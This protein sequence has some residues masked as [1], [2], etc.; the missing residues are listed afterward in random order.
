[1]YLKNLSLRG[2]KT[3]ADKTV[4]EFNPPGSIT[5]IV[6]PNGCGKS[7]LVDAIRWV[8]GEQNPKELRSSALEEVIFAGSSA[9]KPLSLAEVS[10]D[11][12][13]TDNKIKTEFAELSIKRRTFRSGESEFFINKANCRLKDIR[14]IFLDTGLGAGSYSIISQGRVDAVLSSKPEERREIF[15]EAAKINKYKFRK[16]AAERKLISTEQNMLRI[17][18]LKSEISNQLSV[19]EEQSKKAAQ[20][21]ELKEKL[22]VLEVG[23]S[24]RQLTNITEKKRVIDE[25]ISALKSQMELGLNMTQQ[26]EAEKALKKETLRS[27]Q[28]EIEGLRL[29]VSQAKLL[30]EENKSSILLENEKKRNLEERI[31]EAKA[32]FDE[33]SLKLVSLKNKEKEL[34]QELVSSQDTL[35]HASEELARSE[36]SV[37]RVRIEQEKLEGNASE[38]KSAILEKEGALSHERNRFIELESNLRLAKEELR[39]DEELI[40]KL[41]KEKQELSEKLEQLNVRSSSLDSKLKSSESNI[42]F[43]ASTETLKASFCGAHGLAAK[44]ASDG[45]AYEIGMELI[46]GPDIKI[47]NV[48]LNDELILSDGTI[49]GGTLKEKVS[50]VIAKEREIETVIE[51]AKVNHEAQSKDLE[52]KNIT[53]ELELAQRSL[54][55]R[56]K[57]LEDISAKKTSLSKSIASLEVENKT[58]NEKLVKASEALSSIIKEK[59]KL[60]SDYAGSMARHAGIASRTENLLNEKEKIKSETSSINDYLSGRQK[61]EMEARLIQATGR[62]KVLEASLPKI[63]EEEKELEKKLPLKLQDKS[64]LESEIEAVEKRLAGGTS[65]DRITRD[66][67][68]KEEVALAKLEGELIS[69]SEKMLNDYSMTVENVL[70][71]DIGIPP[72]TKAKEEAEQLRMSISELGPVNLLAT[73]E[74]EKA[75]ERFNFIDAQFNDLTMARENLSNLIKEL[76][77]KARE[78][79]IETMKVI[80]RNFSEIFAT[81]FEGGEAKLVT[82]E[83]ED[84]LEGGIEIIARPGGKK[85]LNLSAM[86][87]G[88]RALTAIALLFALLKT[89]PSPFCLMDEADSALDEANVYRFTK[90]LKEFSM[91]TQV[92]LITHNKQTMEIADTMYGITMEEPGISKVVSVKLAKA[93]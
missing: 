26:Y 63:T 93:A 15:E 25:K 73:E 62:I 68:S 35:K 75:R 50:Q 84:I 17:A 58:F 10:I 1:M 77:E 53:E 69:I 87:G 82:P 2:F 71:S 8:L 29:S 46:Y 38:L 81:L 65:E 16:T 86:S 36:E 21:K 27:L 59:E 67:L 51:Q 32:R 11:L 91:Q 52:L 39:H 19:L 48:T 83:G 23:L 64:K 55:A 56:G 5:A 4:I 88:E 85:W 54:A 44:L 6:G 41:T 74:F 22:K 78:D 37:G 43:T 60:L 34:E 40:K 30:Y 20:F 42:E 92:V 47:K 24:K 33:L 90:L 14:D 89:H 72:A 7:N 70:S 49:S 66:A 13:N 61:E 79:F 28:E 45:K 18:D 3:F 76:D 57:E 9:R 31:A 80:N 12:D